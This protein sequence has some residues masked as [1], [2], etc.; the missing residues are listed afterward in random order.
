MFFI[1]AI[2]LSAV[3]ISWAVP[4]D[5][6]QKM[7]GAQV[8]F[9]KVKDGDSPTSILTKHGFKQSDLGIALKEIALPRYLTLSR[10]ELYRVVSTPKQ[11][12]TEVK[13][14]DP[15]NNTAYVF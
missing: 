8:T 2:S 15:L 9:Q 12:F 10:G 6:S 4:N 11:D 14:Y 5:Y 13:I 3:P 7:K 1:F